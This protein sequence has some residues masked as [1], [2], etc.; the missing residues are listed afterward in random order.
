MRAA[1]RPA[2]RLLGS[3]AVDSP[4]GRTTV[5]AGK[6]QALLAW[7]ALHPNTVQATPVLVD[8]VWG[9]RAPATAVA[10]VHNYMSRLRASL[11]GIAVV[12]TTG[13]GYRLDLDPSRIDAH[14]ARAL[15]DEAAAVSASGDPRQALDLIER[16]LS[17]WV[18]EPLHNLDAP[19][20]SVARA[21]LDALRTTLLLDAA[22]EHLRLG[23]P[24][25]RV[26]ET[27]RALVRADPL[28]EQAQSLLIRV[29]HAT[30]NRS[31]ALAQYDVA[32]RA[33]AQDLGVDPGSML[34]EAHAEVLREAPAK[35]VSAAAAEATQTV[36]TGSQAAPYRSRRRAVGVG[37]AALGVVVALVVAYAVTGSDRPSGSPTTARTSA[38]S[39]SA[40]PTTAAAPSPPAAAI[41]AT[42]NLVQPSCCAVSA[43]D[44]WGA[45]HHDM[46]LHEWSRAT[47]R[48]VATFPVVGFQSGLPV[49]AAGSVWVPA[50]AGP[51][52]RF[53]EL[54]HRVTARINVDGA[55]TAFGFEDMWVTSRDHTLVAVS[56]QSNKV[57]LRH[58]YDGGENDW[59]DPLVVAPGGVWVADADAAHLLRFDPSTGKLVARVDGFGSTD[60]S[61]PI[62]YGE[63]AVWVKRYVA[64]REVLFR[65]DPRRDKV[66][67][68][69]ATT[70]AEAGG[71]TG[72]VAVGDGFVWTG[73]S[74]ATLSKIDPR[75]M[76]VVRRFTLPGVAQNVVFAGG[77]LWVDS[78]DTGEAWQIR[79]P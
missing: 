73:N 41:V 13:Q 56:L 43:H 54:R 9:D 53:D 74:D 49:E 76:R 37:V 55:Q 75:T 17:L 28:N 48:E 62:A 11:D 71:F 40:S 5:R 50:P 35:A 77:F 66:T 79:S 52:T 68:K 27:L 47:G 45:G 6:E 60:S 64:D 26:V 1:S 22:R 4:P 14:L 33:L 20:V 23:V 31:D 12:T 69:V 67:G 61:M 63:G 59:D 58:R 34:T 51:L 3:V 72:S 78:Y 30:G 18:G 24:P 25:A 19:Y 32:R 7:L 39:G 8:E 15:R 42:Y 10:I 21:E 65:I 2:I 57:V 46:T 36:P 44:V 38:L 29:L 70:S 16:A